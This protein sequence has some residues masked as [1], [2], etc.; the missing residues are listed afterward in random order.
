MDDYLND[1]EQDELEQEEPEGLEAG[2]GDLYFEAEVARV[3]AAVAE[4]NARYGMRITPEDPEHSAVSWRAKHGETFLASY[5]QALKQK[6]ARLGRPAPDLR[7][8]VPQRQP[9][10]APKRMPTQRR[11]AL[12]EVNDARELIKMGIKELTGGKR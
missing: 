10:P 4:L 8:P 1:F 11:A 3:N 2:L 9:A 5:I 7:Q 12:S 6:A